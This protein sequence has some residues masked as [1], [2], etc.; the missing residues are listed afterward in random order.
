MPIQKIQEKNPQK[1]EKTNKQN[2]KFTF[3]HMTIKQAKC[4]KKYKGGSASLVNGS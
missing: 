2:N 1:T 4:S 3:T